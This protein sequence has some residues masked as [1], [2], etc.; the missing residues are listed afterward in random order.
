MMVMMLTMKGSAGQPCNPPSDGCIC[1]KGTM[2]CRGK[3]VKQLPIL[4]VPHDIKVFTFTE[5]RL[6]EITDIPYVDATSILITKSFVGKIAENAFSNLTALTSL[7][8]NDNFIDN[9]ENLTFTNL[10]NLQT[11]ELRGNGHLSL[12]DGIFDGLKNLQ[13]LDLSDNK[14]EFTDNLFTAPT[15]SL[16]SFMCEGCHLNAVPKRMLSK[17]TGL[18]SLNLNNN[19]FSI[20]SGN[21]FDS[22]PSVEELSLDNCRIERIANDGFNKLSSLSSLNLGNNKLSQIS[23]TTLKPVNETLKKLYLEGNQFQTMIEDR[24]PWSSLTELRLGNNPWT[25]DCLIV[26]M[27]LNQLEKIDKENITCSSPP[28]LLG[29]NLFDVESH[30]ICNSGQQRKTAI[31]LLVAIPVILVCVSLI[32]YYVCQIVRARRRQARQRHAFK[33]RSVYGDTVETNSSKQSIIA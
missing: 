28:G 9:L 14:A 21:A 20:I 25:C 32:S 19:N 26:W 30:L 27:S 1:I 12:P 7:S 13:N 8:I 5:C 24:A 10:K 29:K 6:S 15:A 17:L 18:K 4:N 33:Y 16:S 31:I 22:N 11:L 3:L 2:L 23:Q